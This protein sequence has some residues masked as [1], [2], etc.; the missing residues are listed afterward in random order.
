MILGIDVRFRKNRHRLLASTYLD[1]VALGT[2]AV[3]GMDG[4]MPDDVAPKLSDAGLIADREDRRTGGRAL[5]AEDNLYCGTRDGNIIRFSAPDHAE[6]AFSRESE[7]VPSGSR[8]MRRDGSSP[9]SPAWA[10]CA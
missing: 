9:A 10:S 6:A 8:S 4:L 1:P 7:D 5:D 3:R 2:D